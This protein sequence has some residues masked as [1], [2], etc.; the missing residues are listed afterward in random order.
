MNLKISYSKKRDEDLW[1]DLKS[2]D[3]DAF[4]LLYYKHI[5]SLLNYAYKF[6]Q[7]Q[8]LVEDC[9]Q[10]VF[11]YL[12]QNRSKLSIVNSVKGYL[13][14]MLRRKLA[15]KLKAKKMT[16]EKDQT[17]ITDKFE[18]SI[19]KQI[20]N[21]E[22]QD[23]LIKKLN[24]SVHALPALQREII[25]LKYYGNFST[26]EICEILRINKKSVYNALSKAMCRFRQ[27]F[28]VTLAFTLVQIF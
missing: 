3:K 11:L 6:C 16:D 8:Y 13:F 19:E 9:V 17:H 2:G 10:D 12:W 15:E 26:E 1:L 25:F 24:A 21:N 23:A 14:T 7:N 18:I 27:V 20:I 5:Q 28:I 4:S 22:I